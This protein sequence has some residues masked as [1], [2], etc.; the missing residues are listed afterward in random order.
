MRRRAHVL[1]RLLLPFDSVYEGERQLVPA[2][3]GTLMRKD[4]RLF[5]SRVQF[6]REKRVNYVVMTL[7]KN[8]T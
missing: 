7:K 5:T 3:N 6:T 8:P 1:D 2:K 4:A